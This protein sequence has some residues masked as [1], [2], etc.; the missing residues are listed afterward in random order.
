MKRRVA[1][2]GGGIMGL[3]QAYLLAKEDR[4]EVTLFS[5]QPLLETATIA[6][7]A[8]WMP[9]KALPEEK[10]L[11]WA[12]KSLAYYTE[13][14]K[15]SESGVT[16]K[17]HTEFFRKPT[18]M[19][20]WMRL[21]PE[22]EKSNCNIPEGAICSYSIRIPIIDTFRLVNYLLTL[23]HELN[24]SIVQQ[25]ITNITQLK[26]FNILINASGVGAKNFVHDEKVFPIKGQ[27]F[28]LPQ[29]IERISQS[30]FYDNGDKVILVIPHEEHVTIGVTVHEN[31]ASTH[32]DLE[33]EQEL[34]ALACRLYP[35]LSGLQV[36]E[37]RVGIR[38]G[39][40]N[41]IRLESEIIS[42]TGQLLVHN[43]GH[44]G[45]GITLG[46]G[47]ADA[48]MAEVAQ[49]EASTIARTGL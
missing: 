8:I 43:Y 20:S 36:L 27:T 2:I 1:I 47:C 11:Q 10:V 44:A 37:R 34:Y 18:D 3:F 33:E 40:I 46:P 41:G 39:R 30:V 32:Y 4:Y 15:T 49:F 23:I 31:D 16:F 21:V 14:A 25:K 7:G 28:K 29:P 5:D 17:T 6:A 19:P 24:V 48:V 9:Y 22:G 38:P 26:D 35:Q 13:L 42:D 45:G 12:K